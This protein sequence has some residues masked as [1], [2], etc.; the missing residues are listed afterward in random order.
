MIYTI[1]ETNL[2]RQH[3]LAKF[4]NPLTILALQKISLKK[5]SKILDM[6]CG[7]GETTKMLSA[8]FPET[9]LTGLDQ[10]EALIEEA[11]D[12]KGKPGSNMKFV[13]GDALDL[14]F[15]DNH[16]DFVFARY[17]IHHIPDSYAALKEMKRVCKAGGIIFVHEPDVNFLQSY[18]ESWAYP[19]LKEFVNLLFADARLGRKL[20]SYF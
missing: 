4:L 6:G 14:P 3:L 15:E 18:P 5:G 11:N 13:T 17:L 8:F 7:L 1:E 19:K 9:D 2:E 10:D 16:F 12:T 20:I